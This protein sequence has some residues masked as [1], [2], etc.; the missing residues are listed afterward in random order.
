MSAAPRKLA[1]AVLPFDNISGDPEQSYFSD[2]LTEDIIAG[3]SRFSELLVIAR[4]SS[5]RFRGKAADVRDIGRQLSVQFIVEGSVRKSSNRVRV[6]VELIDVSSDAQVWAAQYDRALTD[7][8][9]IQD[10]ITGA[11][12]SQIVGHARATVATRVRTQPTESLSAYDLFLQAREYFSSDLTA[13]K[14]EPFLKRAIELDPD[15]ADAHALLSVMHTA[16]YLLNSKQ[17]HLEKAL[18]FAQRALEIDP[19]GPLANHS[20]GY[21]SSFMGRT[22]EAGHYLRQSIALNPNE[23]Y[24]RG[25][26]ANWLNYSG[27]TAGAL[28]EIEE[29]FR[30]DPY[31]NDWFWAVRGNIEASSGLYE[32][33][34]ASLR[35][36]KIPSNWSHLLAAHCCVELGRMSEARQAMARYRQMTEVKPSDYVA[37]RPYADAQRPGRIMKNLQLAEQP[38]PALAVVPKTLPG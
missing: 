11:V 25:E 5:F 19:A 28:R 34:L 10:E 22:Q 17:H 26:Y 21:V 29:A 13:W 20:L 7:V 3:L 37:A 24:F 27:D 4:N 33:A 6:T 18:S 12:L 31:G 32:V 15:F 1:I 14:A 36:M 9:A 35:R 38:V 23:A 2:G 30:R 8:F 16:C